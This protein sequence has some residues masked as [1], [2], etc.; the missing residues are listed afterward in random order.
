MAKGFKIKTNFSF[1]KLANKLPDIVSDSLNVMGNHI[2][3]AIQ[4][5]LDKGED[6]EGNPFEPLGPSTLALRKSRGHGTKILV[7]SGK[8]RGTKKTPA[9]D[10]DPIF[11]LEM[12][13]AYGAEHNEGYVVKK[14]RFKGSTV[15]KRKWF[16]IPKSALPG[17]KEWKKASLNRKFRI[18]RALKTIMK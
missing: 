16:G 1:K 10:S 7:A 14:G 2:N 12:R 13:K 6:I 15:P 9:T 8:M 3:K 5:G 17:G 4:D 11:K 18:A